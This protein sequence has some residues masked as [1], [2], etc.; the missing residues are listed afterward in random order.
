M[1]HHWQTLTPAAPG[2]LDEARMQLHYA[3]QIPSA[4]GRTWLP[5][6]D[7]D[8]HTNLA[9]LDSIRGLAGDAAPREPALA[10]GLDLENLRLLL[11]SPAGEVVAQL[12]LAGRTMEEGNAWL[13]EQLGERWGTEAGAVAPLH[14]DMPDHPLGRGARFEADP[15]SG[16]PSRATAASASG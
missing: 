5:R 8:S 6:K 3:P 1:A 12:E 13:A 9:W 4:L 15:A 2:A 10:A 11:L 14:H 16:C 7:D